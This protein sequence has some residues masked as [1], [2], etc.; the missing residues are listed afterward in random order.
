MIE[1]RDG[2]VTLHGRVQHAAIWHGQ[3]R[4]SAKACQPP[5]LCLIDATARDPHLPE[6]S[7]DEIVQAVSR[8]ANEDFGPRDAVHDD[9]V[10]RENNVECH[11]SVNVRG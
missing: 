9:L 3:A 8:R 5:R 11:I 1:C 6:L 7:I 2:A 10:I 4:S